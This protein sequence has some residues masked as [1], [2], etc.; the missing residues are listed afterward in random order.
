[1]LKIDPKNIQALS[2]RARIYLNSGKCS[3]A[4]NDYKDVLKLKPD[5]GDATKMIQK[6]SE[7]ADLI[8]R[9]ERLIL[10]RS[11][12]KADHLLTEAM[13]ITGGTTPH[14]K[15]LRARARLEMGNYV[16][17]IADAG[18]VVKIENEN[19]EALLLR[20]R[21]YYA[22]AD[23]EMTMRHLRESLKFDPE[24]VEAKKLF[25]Q[26]KKI[27]AKYNA[28]EE[29]FNKGQYKEA[30]ENYL[31][32]VGIDPGH[33]EFNKGVYLKMCRCLTELRQVEK[34][35]EVCDKALDIDG[36]LIDAH[37]II[38]EYLTKYAETTQ[39][40]ENAVAGWRKALQIDRN[41][42]VAQDGLRRAEAGLKQ[43]K[44]KNYYKT[45]EVPRHADLATIKRQYRKLALVY[46]PDKHSDK[47][48]EEKE[49]VTVIFQEI[50]EAYEVLSNPELRGKYDRGE[51]VFENQGGQQQQHHG[52]PF[53]FFQNMH[54]QHG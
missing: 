5:H 35:M 13:Q 37:I 28:G 4:L 1:M 20:G 33:N 42:P 14:L 32:A 26:L 6:V 10:E 21:A 24:H 40:F 36:N 48:E 53:H 34:A 18:E 25:N 11:W 7:C 43:S 41:S 3:E 30:Y 31:A 2:L 15:M 50:S 52:F 49:K 54:F 8:T 51:E 23:H 17:C 47:S 44:K 19:I 38:S 46:H 27:I 29:E 22:T 39:E 45:L 16:E 12:E 9:A